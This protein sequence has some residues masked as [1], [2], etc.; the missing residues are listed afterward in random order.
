MHVRPLRGAVALGLLAIT[1]QPTTAS[2]AAVC[3][4]TNNVWFSPRLTTAGQSGWFNLSYSKQCVRQNGTIYSAAQS[5]LSFPYVG[6]C[7]SATIGS[8]SL[9]NLI[10][11]VLNLDPNKV[12]LLVPDSLNPCSFGSGS[13]YAIK[14]D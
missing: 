1:L 4:E 12:M 11:G 2:A 6:S 7:V 14:I 10:G 5:G 3:V 13:G 9:P 8:G